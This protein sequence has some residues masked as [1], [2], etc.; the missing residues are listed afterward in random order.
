MQIEP[1]GV[2]GVVHGRTIELDHELGLPAGHRVAVIV[3]ALEHGPPQSAEDAIRRSAGGWNDDPEGLTD[4]LVW[5]RRQRKADR[6]EV[7]P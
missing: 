7:Q 1:Q 4:Y 5:N 6:P 2:E 3:R